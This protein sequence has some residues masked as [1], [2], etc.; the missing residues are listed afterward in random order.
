ME[1]D[2]RADDSG[3]GVA[4]RTGAGAADDAGRG[5][6]DGAQ[7]RGTEDSAD[8]EGHSTIFFTLRGRFAPLTRALL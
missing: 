3:G 1:E 4:F 7:G 5:A 6:A 2:S 8:V